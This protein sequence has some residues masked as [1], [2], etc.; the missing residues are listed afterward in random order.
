MCGVEA[1]L[2]TLTP[3]VM[4]ISLPPAKARGTL[5]GGQGS[6]RAEGPREALTSRKESR[7]PREG[8]M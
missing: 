6:P 4:V 2:K 7:G 5:E 3:S 8:G 1:T